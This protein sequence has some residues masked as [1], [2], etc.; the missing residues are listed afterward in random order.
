MK[1]AFAPVIK[2][3]SAG[4]ELLDTDISFLTGDESEIRFLHFE[5]GEGFR[6]TEV[7]HSRLKDR[8]ALVGCALASFVLIML[9]IG[10][11]RYWTGHSVGR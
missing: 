1:A 4:N 6:A 2:Q 8:L 11:V 9:L 7:R 5:R 3:L 10:G